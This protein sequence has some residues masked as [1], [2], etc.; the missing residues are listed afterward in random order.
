MKV[1][2]PLRSTLQLT[3]SSP[4]RKIQ[5]AVQVQVCSLSF[6]GG[7]SQ[8]NRK[9]AALKA[10]WLNWVH[11]ASYETWI[12]A[13][14]HLR[15]NGLTIGAAVQELQNNSHN[16]IFQAG[17]ISNYLETVSQVRASKRGWLNTLLS[18]LLNDE[19]VT[20]RKSRWVQQWLCVSTKQ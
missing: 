6:L 18:T 19:P 2:G 13:A 1:K 4:L 8:K 10:V 3:V 14:C 9:C 17:P 15:S 5:R 7:F 16:E 11:H 20:L 12:C